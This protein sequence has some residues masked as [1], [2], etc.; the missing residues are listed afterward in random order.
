MDAGIA[1][2]GPWRPQNLRQR[3]DCSP[4][5]LDRPLLYGRPVAAAQQALRLSGELSLLD[6]VDSVST[7]ILV[8]AEEGAVVFANARATELFGAR[9]PDG[10]DPDARR[11]DVAELLA[12]LDSLLLSQQSGVARRPSLRVTHDGVER[13]FGYTITRVAHDAPE[14]P[15]VVAFQDVTPLVRL[16]EERDRLLKLATVGEVMPML[17][18]E[19][20]NPLAAAITTLELLLEERSEPALQ[21]ELHGVLVEIRRA[22]LSLEGLGAVGRQLRTSRPHAIDHAVREVVALLEPRARRHGVELS[23]DVPALPLLPLDPSSLRGIVLNLVTN[24]IQ[25]CRDGRRCVVVKLRLDGTTVTLDVTDT[26]CGMTPDVLAR[27]RELFFS[28][29][30]NGSGV[31]LALCARLVEEAGGALVV[32]SVLGQGTHIEIAVPNVGTREQRSWADSASGAG[33][34]VRG[35]P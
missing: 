18:H 23:C 29:K 17:L 31:G 21:E 8:V 1:R 16:E 19:T 35:R 34:A 7:A 32:G 26:G 9:F 5:S 13:V 3:G 33:G 11:Y 30:S 14:R 2:E 10:F 20:K 15:F 28:T 4:F 27:C 6:V 22:L 24:A 12:P 25:A